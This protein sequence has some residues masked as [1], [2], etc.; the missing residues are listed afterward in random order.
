MNAE[1]DVATTSPGRVSLTFSFTRAVETHSA[2]IS[3]KS[4]SEALELLEVE[5][6]KAP[7][8]KLLS[9]IEASE[10]WEGT[11]RFARRLPPRQP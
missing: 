7:S 3:S 6:V 10:K 1:D 11:R 8:S 2:E 4:A 9:V 5:V